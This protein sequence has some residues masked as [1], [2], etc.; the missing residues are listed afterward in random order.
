ML[1]P[2][3]KSRACVSR[4]R[5]MVAGGGEQPGRAGNAALIA[6]NAGAARCHQVCQVGA[7]QA[8][9]DEGGLVGADDQVGRVGGGAGPRLGAGAGEGDVQH[10][11]ADVDLVC[12]G[13]PGHRL[14]RRG[15][16]QVQRE[17]VSADRLLRTGRVQQ[18]GAPVG[19]CFHHHASP[20]ARVGPSPWVAG[21]RPEALGRGELDRDVDDA[22]VR[23]AR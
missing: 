6:G 8:E 9:L 16:G 18:L 15:Y 19:E 22:P 11:A 21:R 20:Q 4:R 2:G 3:R 13:R 17:P 5:R 14:G 12:L 10:L 23:Q 1:L 7:A